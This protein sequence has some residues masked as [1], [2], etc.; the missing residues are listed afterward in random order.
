M[1]ATSFSEKLRYVFNKFLIDFVKYV[2]SSDNELKSISKKHYR[3]I[4]KLTEEHIAYA[5]NDVFTDVVIQCLRSAE[6]DG[7]LEKPEIS[8]L[9]LIRGIAVKDLVLKL[10][11][12]EHSTIR[13]YV[14]VFAVLSLVYRNESE[15]HDTD[16]AIEVLTCILNIIRKV[17]DADES[18]EEDIEEI[19]VEEYREILG[20]LA[21]NAFASTNK[22]TCSSAENVETGTE[23]GTERGTGAGAGPMP[24]FDALQN[25]TIGSLAKEISEEIDL[26]KLNL[27]KPEELLNMANLAN[28][29]SQDNV[30]GNIISKVGSKIQ[31]KIAS[32]ELRH[33]QLLSEAFSFMKDMNLGGSGGGTN[34]A[35]NPLASLLNNPMIQS[36][37]G[38]AA[39]GARPTVNESKMRAASERDR[40][41]RKLD[42]R[43]K[44]K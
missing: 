42:E 9:H 36:M 22:D 37:M 14:Y 38:G 30:L 21:S 43:K 17:Q 11:A 25:T 6:P 5:S 40:L 23:R 12:N 27:E 26:S 18:A 34:S 19:L 20:C 2:N 7:V 15:A 33:D 44:Q 28:L 1:E 35:E 29:T 41:R 39:K 32:G 10:S 8:E 24:N 16:S 31:T 4:D 13:F 3:A